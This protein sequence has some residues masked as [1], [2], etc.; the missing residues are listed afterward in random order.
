MSYELEIVE[1][2]GYVVAVL[3]GVRTPE[4]LLAAAARTTTFCSE[5]QISHLLIDLK[6]MTGRLD[7]LETF[8]IAGHELP[9]QKAVRRVLRSV[10]LD[11]PENVE[12][13]RFFETVAINRGLNV[14]VFSDEDQAVE[15]LL[16]DVNGGAPPRDHG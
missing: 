10:I 13:L 15:W 1:K 7:T 14:K 2:S 3:K 12:R 8:D 5:R 16:A 9:R 4:T 6:G 11:H